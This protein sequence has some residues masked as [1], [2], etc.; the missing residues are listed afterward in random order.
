[1]YLIYCNTNQK[2]C[3]GSLP[4]GE[5]C[6]YEVS[7]YSHFLSPTQMFKPQ[8]PLMLGSQTVNEDIDH[9]VSANELTS[10]RTHGGSSSQT[11]QSLP[12]EAFRQ[13]FI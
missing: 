8:P 11:A 12:P 9:S 2:S 6:F 7:E 5:I 1:M 3:M 13:S 4:A 10:S